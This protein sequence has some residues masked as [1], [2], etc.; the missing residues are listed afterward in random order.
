MNFDKEKF[1]QHIS[2]YT[3]YPD[4]QRRT[5][6]AFSGWQVK[7]PNVFFHNT[8][9]ILN[10]LEE[11]VN[12]IEKFSRDVDKLDGRDKLEGAVELLDDLIKVGWIWEWA[13][14]MVL[15]YLLTT[16]VQQKNK[17]VGKNWFTDDGT[18]KQ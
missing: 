17:Y 16:V 3:N 5:K 7:D 1:L 15:R 11:V 9:E 14:G 8:R 18:I 12:L 6:E 10:I 13:D 4:L 2:K